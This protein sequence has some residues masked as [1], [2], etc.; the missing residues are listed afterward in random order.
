VLLPLGAGSLGEFHLPRRVKLMGSK[1]SSP[2]QGKETR[3]SAGDSNKR[4]SS[5]KDRKYEGGGSL[6]DKTAFSD[7]EEE[8]E[9]GETGDRKGAVAT[10]ERDRD[11]SDPG[12]I[13]INREYSRRRRDG[14]ERKVSI[15]DF[16]LLQVCV[17][18]GG[19]EREEC[20]VAPLFQR[21]P[22]LCLHRFLGGV[23]LRRFC[24]YATRMT[25]NCTL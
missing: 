1:V 9:E 24:S 18:C 15:G 4:G 11:G 19:W 13:S 10:A 23:A 5:S 14:V 17:H 16:E 12:F 8:E 2:D 25:E 20:N 6:H 3:D 7:E 22:L 21:K